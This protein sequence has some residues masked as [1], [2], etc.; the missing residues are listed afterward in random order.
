[1][2]TRESQKVEKSR[3]L[4]LFEDFAFPPPEGCATLSGPRCVPVSDGDADVSR[5]VKDR[6]QHLLI[7]KCAVVKNGLTIPLIST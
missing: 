1:M 4:A 2:H 7:R 6:A 5:N 3:K